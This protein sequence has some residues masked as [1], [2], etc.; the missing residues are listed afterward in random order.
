[1]RKSRFIERQIVVILK[2]VGAGHPSR[3][4]PVLESDNALSCSK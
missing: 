4:R 3:T 2:Q 1:M